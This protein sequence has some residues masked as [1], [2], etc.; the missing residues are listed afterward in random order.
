[1][2]KYTLFERMVLFGS[3]LCVIPVLIIGF[4]S[5]LK[6]SNAIQHEVNNSNVHVM[7]QMNGNIE[8][9]LRTLDHTLNTVI[10]SA[11]VQDALDRPVTFYDFQLYNALKR[12]MS[13]L[14]SP[15]RK[16]TDVVLVNTAHNWFIN[17][18][19]LYPLDASEQK[20][21]IMNLMNLPLHSQWV[22]HEKG[23]LGSKDTLSYG[24][25]YTITLVKKLPIQTF[26]KK[27]LILAHIPSCSLASMLSTD[28]SQEAMILDQDFRIVA[29]P[30][31]NQVGRAIWDTGYMTEKQ[32]EQFTSGVG[33]FET[34]TNQ[35]LFTATYVRSEFNGWTYISF[36]ENDEITQEARDIGWFTFF[37]CMLIIGA[38]VVI[39]WFGT[40]R[41]YKPLGTIMQAITDKLPIQQDQ[42]K[43]E[44]QLINEHIENLFQSNTTLKTEL[45]QNTQL[46]RTTFLQ[47]VFTGNIKAGE[48]QERLNMY[49]FDEQI[50]PWKHMN[51]LTLQIDMLD[52]SRFTQKDLDLILFAINNIVEETIPVKH[53]LSPVLLD[54]T[55][56]TL[57]GSSDTSHEQ[58]TETVD[59][60]THAIQRNVRTYLELDV[61]IGISLPFNEIS[62]ASRAYREGLEALKHRITLGTGVIIR[63]AYINS[64]KHTIIQSFPQQLEND[65]IDAVKLAEEEKALDLLKQWMREVFQKERS[66]QQH[67]VSLMRLLND[68]LI[69]MQDS[70]ISLAQI[71]QQEESL[72]DELLQLYVG[73][74]IEKW[75]RTRIIL[76]LIQIFRDRSES[77]YRNL[78]E[79]IIDLI[80]KYYDTDLTLEECASRLH[81]NTFY[82]S[83]VFKKETNLS[84]SEYL[85]MYRFNMAKKWLKETDMTV[86]DIAQKLG[87]NNPQ[88]FIR[89]FRKQEDMT[90]GQYRTKYGGGE[91]K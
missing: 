41:M 70:G 60:W 29:H 48:L 27:G 30:D 58:F 19:G 17:N 8:Q 24:C 11:T 12:E 49:G 1:L 3:L 69:V 80:H 13:L 47:K 75:F 21:E 18:S 79:E 52:S 84:F 61:S 72:Y 87:Y 10:N 42:K 86:K 33:Q 64:G 59:E 37:V 65:L 55:Q 50:E 63:Y 51:V 43:D 90:P 54:Q 4:F 71:Q 91:D 81:Y 85:T 77:Q 28:A 7:K 68:L 76:P 34:K 62:K 89:S 73:D 45:H 15:E 26:D 5:Y 25:K 39:V 16:V 22:V 78:S 53:R 44:F 6:S 56:V 57:I 83:S 74:E 20:T 32:R 38:S 23:Q 36:T 67:Q 31:E 66:P 2:R 46:V 40:R 35:G 14:Q 9:V 82:L 88:N